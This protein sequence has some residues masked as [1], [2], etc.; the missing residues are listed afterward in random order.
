MVRLLPNMAAVVATGVDVQVLT[1][2]QRAAASN[3]LVSSEQ[4]DG[5][6]VRVHVLCL[7]TPQR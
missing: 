3:D 4:A 7:V 1:A 6:G 5:G 2:L